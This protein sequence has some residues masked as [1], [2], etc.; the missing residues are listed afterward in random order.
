MKRDHIQ[1]FKSRQSFMNI[2]FEFPNIN[3]G[4][5]APNNPEGHV[6]RQIIVVVGEYF[7]LL[8]LSLT[9]KAAPH[10]CVFRT[11]QP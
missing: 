3:I 5:T 10:E 11:S 4:K 9:V 1:F 2:L 6:F 7:V 8:D